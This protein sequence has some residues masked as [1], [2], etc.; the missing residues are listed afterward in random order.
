VAGIT[1]PTVSAQKASCMMMVECMWMCTQWVLWPWIKLWQL[2]SWGGE[3][4]RAF[5]QQIHGTKHDLGP[6]LFFFDVDECLWMTPDGRKLGI[7]TFAK[8]EI[9]MQIIIQ[10]LQQ[11]DLTYIL[12]VKH[13]CLSLQRGL[14]KL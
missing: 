11:Y 6:W 10:Q 12:E 8:F 3:T 2:D 5:P 4:L 1:M 13:Q 14:C 9:H 7:C